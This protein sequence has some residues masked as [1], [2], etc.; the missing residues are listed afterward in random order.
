MTVAR[1]SGFRA[2]VRGRLHLF[3]WVSYGG[4]PM[5]D[6]VIAELWNIKDGIAEEWGYDVKAYAA[7][8]RAK[9][10]AA[11]RL[12][13]TLKTIGR[14]VERSDVPEEKNKPFSGEE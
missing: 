4:I 2:R 11:D 14:I 12:V 9:E 1:R 8:L 5:A 6:E 7:H 3:A 13:V 10:G